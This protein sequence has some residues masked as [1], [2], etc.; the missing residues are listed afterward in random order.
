MQ[1][2]LA[3][4]ALATAEV[5]GPLADGAGSLSLAVGG[6]AAIAALSAALVMTDPGRRRSAQ[7]EET[8]GDELEAVKKYFDT[9]GFDRWNKIYGDTEEVNKVGE[10]CAFFLFYF[11]FI[12]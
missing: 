8:G 1:A 3:T 11:F 5:A 6:G 12:F 10:R 4:P 9:A 7:M 2:V